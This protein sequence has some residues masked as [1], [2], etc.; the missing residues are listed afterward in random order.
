MVVAVPDDGDDDD[1]VAGNDDHDEDTRNGDHDEGHDAARHG[2]GDDASPRCHQP[3]RQPQ[4]SWH[5][6]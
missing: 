4:Q 6:T 1:N 3:Q 5:K 2:D